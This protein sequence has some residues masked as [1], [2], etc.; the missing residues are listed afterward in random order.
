MLPSPDAPHNARVFNA[1]MSRGPR[2]R[3]EILSPGG[4]RM[5]ACNGLIDTGADI[6][7]FEEDVYTQL[8]YTPVSKIHL[9]TATGTEVRGLYNIHLRLPEHSPVYRVEIQ[10]AGLPQFGDGDLPFGLIGR[11]LLAL[12]ELKYDGRR[13]VFSLNL[14][15]PSNIG[16]VS[17]ESLK[18][19]NPYGLNLARILEEAA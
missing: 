18:R 2:L 5:I 9:Q 12:G 8:G 14:D 6:T 17:R 11:D 4:D 3:V 1:L 13:G 7:S 10:V 15:R 19:N 16:V